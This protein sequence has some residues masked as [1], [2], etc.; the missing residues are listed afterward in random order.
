M[1]VV[2]ML[3]RYCLFISVGSASFVLSLDLNELYAEARQTRIAQGHAAAQPLYAD[4]LLAKN[5]SD[6]TTSTH[7]ASAS[8]EPLHLLET[9]CTNLDK[10]KLAQL[11]DWFIAVGFSTKGVRD[12]LGIPASQTARAPV[13]VTPA[14][15]GTVNQLPFA[16]PT[17]SQYLITLFLLGLAVPA[18]LECCS[19]Q[20]IQLLLDL[21]LVCSCE[22]D[23]NLLVAVVSIMPVDLTRMGG[24]DECNTL[25]VVTDWHPR[26]LNAIKIT[27]EEEAVMYI[28]ADSLALL[29]HWILHPDLPG[30]DTMLDL[31][32]G[33]GIQALACAYLGKCKAAVCVDINPRALRFTAFSAALNGLT[34]C[35]TL[36]QGDLLLG[37]GRIVLQDTSEAAPDIELEDLLCGICSTGLG[38]ATPS[39][40]SSGFGMITA[41]PPFLPV[42]TEP[43]DTTSDVVAARY[44]WFSAGGSSGEAVLAAILALSRKILQPGGYTAIVS[45]FFFQDERAEAADNLLDRLRLYWLGTKADR[46]SSDRGLLFSNQFPISAQ[47]YAERRAD[48]MEETTSW[49]RHLERVK[50]ATCSP[51]LL[52]IQKKT[53]GIDIDDI[54]WR[55]AIVPKSDWGSVWTPS[56]PDAIHFT[57]TTSRE[58]FGM[59]I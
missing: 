40:L 14:A 37:T 24:A 51:G 52:Y 28:G 11:R 10:E 48:S 57:Q 34:D 20:N 44:G 33:S 5:P 30:V 47:L 19:P 23:D 42:P 15:A 43:H 2:E 25:Y 16:S 22:H 39:S 13:Y 45:E 1:F 6:L 35:F 59:K 54:S 12:A 50:I 18:D 36:V 21:G 49:L 29:Q 4:L 38:L 53:D 9:A 26:V 58:Y 8:G 3:Y 7:L 56:N 41:N 27:E 17:Q 31:C 55:N 46:V 32:T